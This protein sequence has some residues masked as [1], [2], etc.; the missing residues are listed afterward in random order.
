MPYEIT[1]K[2]AEKVVEDIIIKINNNNNVEGCKYKGVNDFADSSIKY[3]LEINCNP[4]YKLQVKRD[5]LRSILIGMEEN[6][7]K[8][9]YTQIDIHEK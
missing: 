1:V 2:K 5:A 9:P 7:L 3:L 6:N 4:L 8:V